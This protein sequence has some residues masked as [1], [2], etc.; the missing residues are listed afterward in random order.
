[1]DKCF[2]KMELTILLNNNLIYLQHNKK[3]LNIIKIKF[4]LK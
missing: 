3:N 4:C 1:M 2:N